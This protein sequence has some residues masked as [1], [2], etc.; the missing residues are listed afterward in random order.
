[1]QTSLEIRGARMAQ[2][3]LKIAVVY[4]LLGVSFGLWMGLSHQ[5]QFAPA[6]AHANLLGW[7]TLALAGVIYWLCPRAGGHWLGIVHFWLHNLGLPVF[8]L[9][10]FF[11]TAGHAAAQPIV[12]LG[13]TVALLGIAFFAVNLFVNLK[14]A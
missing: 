8:V 1:M 5:F 9:G 14:K 3:W 7:A 11:L 2:I 10:L 13:A 4:L 12:G 6:H